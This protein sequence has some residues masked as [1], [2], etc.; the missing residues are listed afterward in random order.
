MKK[1]LAL[2]IVMTITCSLFAQ[3]SNSGI[4]KNC[5]IDLK[6]YYKLTKSDANNY[7]Y[8][9][10]FSKFSTKF[11]KN[12]FMNLVYKNGV[13][14]SIDS[15]LSKAK[16]NLMANVFHSEQKIIENLED[17]IYKTVNANTTFTDVEKQNW[18]SL[19]SK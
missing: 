3:Q 11:E 8:Q 19:N 17:V 2:M 15:D 12:Y 6:S 9:I 1:V 7:Y 18:M 5:D 4:K 14:V 13:L 16:I 10:D